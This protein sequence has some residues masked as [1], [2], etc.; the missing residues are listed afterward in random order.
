MTEIAART[1]GTCQE[2]RGSLPRP[3]G[4]DLGFD[5]FERLTMIEHPAEAAD[6]FRGK[7]DQGGGMSRRSVR[8]E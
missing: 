1:T 7:L 6:S 2:V 3:G 4:K 8:G 5:L